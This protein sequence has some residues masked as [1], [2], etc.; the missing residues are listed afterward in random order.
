MNMGTNRQI[1]YNYNQIKS[2]LLRKRV[3][4]CIQICSL[5]LI[6]QTPEQKVIVSVNL[7]IVFR[8]LSMDRRE[9]ITFRDIFICRILLVYV[10][11]I[12]VF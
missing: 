9:V 4:I 3:P 2:N 8:T 6:Q 12:F 5:T 1:I 11:Q 10:L 7:G